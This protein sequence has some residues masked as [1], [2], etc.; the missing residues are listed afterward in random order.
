[1]SLINNLIRL[2]PPTLRPGYCPNPA[3]WQQFANDLIGGTRATILLD[4]GSIF[5][6]YGDTTPEP[7]N[8][9]FPWIHT[10]NGLLWIF[11]NGLW[12]SPRPQVD[13]GFRWMWK[14]AN[15]TAESA[16][17]S[18]GGGDGTDPSTNPPTAFTGAMWSVDHDMDGIFP[19]GVGTIPDTDPAV[20]ITLGQTGGEY[21]HTLTE[22]EGAVGVHTHPFGL[23][24]QAPGDD[25][26]FRKGTIQTVPGYTGF[27]ITGSNGVI[28]T[29][30]TQ[31]DLQTLP[32]GDGKGVPEPDAFKIMP[33][34][35]GVYWAKPT[36]RIY[37]TLPA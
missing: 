5:F 6:N 35:R 15:G 26:F 28:S 18:V 17:W 19:I 13:T 31:A 12:T 14:P 4:I 7:E 33:K 21:E 11:K 24:N 37:L 9:S 8:R 16:I 10:G 23:T 30:Q 36:N 32:S 34:Y 2:I 20:S 3:T 1:M 29:Q 25:A 27:Y 22:A